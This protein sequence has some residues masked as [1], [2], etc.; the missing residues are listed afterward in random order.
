MNSEELF[1]IE[2][3][4]NYIKSVSDYNSK[5]FNRIKLIEEMGE[6]QT[7]LA[8]IQTKPVGRTSREV[9]D[10]IADVMIRTEILSYNYD[11]DYILTRIN[12]KLK[13]YKKHITEKKYENR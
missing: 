4:D 12:T 9:E 10:E 1:T 13:K 5:E 3:K 8:R 11:R 7:E 6:L 2:N